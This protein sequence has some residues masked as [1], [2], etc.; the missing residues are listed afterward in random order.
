LLSDSRDYRAAGVSVYSDRLLA[1]LP[2]TAPAHHFT[3]FVGPS[4]ADRPG[5]QLVR[6][7][8]P[9]DRPLV[10]IAWE[11]AVLPLQ[12][13]RY[14][15]DLLHSLVNVLPEGYRGCSVV[16]VHD[17]SFLRFPDRLSRGRRL[18]LE[19]MVARSARRA[20]RVIAVSSS[21][22]DDLVELAGVREDRISV[23]FPG[24]DA[25]FHRLIDPPDP[26]PAS[27]EGRPY[28]LHVGTLEPRKNQDVLI[29]AFG[30][31]KAEHG[32][33]HV[34]AL[35]GGRGWMYETLFELVA[36]LAL[37]RDVVFLD[38]VPPAQLPAWYNGADLFAYPSAFEGFGLPVLEAMACGVPTVTSST[39][40]LAEL[41]GNAC[42]T[43]QPG[44]EEA[45]E[46]AMAAI[47]EDDEL[48][49]RLS[50]AGLRRATEFSWARCARET[51]AVYH[52]ALGI[53]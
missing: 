17:L 31:L 38:Y 29:R 52:S 2:E 49:K 35:I 20:T 40:S 28:I 25:A 33:P 4:V 8:L 23:V 50:D 48:R 1:A 45:L 15:V 27:F 21:T 34:L 51:V 22:R 12:S 24:V 39:S 18:Y 16:T 53:H 9:V 37:Q 5:I 10:R 43:V 3:A 42:M 36:A 11:Q 44:C 6:A 19:A 46:R 30:R 13:R 7:P 26:W 32:I 41:A 47:L 14:R